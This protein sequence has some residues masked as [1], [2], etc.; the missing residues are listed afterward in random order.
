MTSSEILHAVALSVTAAPSK[1]DLWELVRR[2]PASA[3]YSLLAEKQTHRTQDF[4]AYRYPADPLNAAEAIIES[5]RKKGI[6]VI[7]FWDDDYPALLRE[8]RTAPLA[9]YTLGSGTPGRCVSIVGTRNAD[10][11]SKKTARRLG[12]DLGHSGFTVV[13]GMAAGVDRAA[14]LGAAGSRGGT[15]GVLAN[16]IDIIYPA[17]NRDIYESL[18]KDPASLLI[19][20]YPPGIRAGKWTFVR[21]N[22]IISGLSYGTVVVQAGE[23]S[24]AL[25]TARYALEQNREVFACPGPAFNESYSGCHNLIRNGAIPVSGTEDVISGLPE[26]I[27]TPCASSPQCGGEYRPR[28]EKKIFHVPDRNAASAYP[29]HSLERK[30][31]DLLKNNCNNIDDIIRTIGCKTSRLNEVITALEIEGIVAKTGNSLQLS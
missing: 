16:G 22:R 14:H 20:E 10:M 26:Y 9:L 8:I 29:E 25:I 31:L 11:D 30:I 15:V 5:S 2:A 3:I 24:G 13:S 23:K 19:S 4:I 28:D 6:R 7:T 1:H 17:Q 21:R 27:G 12:W 18:L